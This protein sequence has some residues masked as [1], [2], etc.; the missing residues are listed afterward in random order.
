MQEKEIL[1]LASWY[2]NEKNPVSGDFIQRHA[3][4]VSKFQRLTVIYM[5]QSGWLETSTLNKT[6]I[7][8]SG[9]LTEIRRYLPFRKTGI[10]MF[11]RIAYNLRYFFEYKRLLKKKF[12]ENGYP[13]LI[14][15]HVPM[16]AGKLALWAKRKWGIPY[17]IS[18]QASTYIESA[19]DYF[20]KRNCYYRHSVRKIFKGAVAVTN[21]SKTVA[22][23]IENKMGI[24]AIHVIHNT[25]DEDLFFQTP[26]SEKKFR[27]IHVSTMIE[28][29]NI[30]GLLDTFKILSSR[31][32][33]WELRLVGPVSTQ[34]QNRLEALKN[35]I[36][37]SYS[38]EIP[39]R[40]V[41]VEM[42]QASAFVLFSNHENFPCVIVEAL[43]CGLP[44]I[45]SDA[46][47]SGE[48]I[49]IKNGKVVPVGNQE[50]LLQALTE[51]LDQDQFY[52][53]S[54][55]AVNA[56]NRFSYTVIGQQYSSLYDKI[57]EPGFSP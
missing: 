23:I 36:D 28:Q 57:L 7:Q 8:T 30:A 44:V 38:G 40:Q 15:V 39:Y 13:Q 32:K 14:H 34:L 45:T 55:I 47:G 6:D 11:D 29:K 3:L 21:V 18:E 49:D 31:R 20:E 2:P 24:D 43:A 19:P 50:K 27:F 26:G 9:N 4:A 16:K 52:N 37:L 51:M 33:D 53:K 48:C 1:W 5:D 22:S 42:Q 46:G 41:A 17:I 10:K 56:I 35:D 25:V 54:E 12:T